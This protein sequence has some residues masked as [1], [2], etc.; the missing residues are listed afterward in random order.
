MDCPATR[1]GGPPAA[2]STY[3]RPPP[4]PRRLHP[5]LETCRRPRQSA[6]GKDG[7]TLTPLRQGR[8]RRPT[9]ELTAVRPDGSIVKTHL[10]APAPPP[11][12]PPHPDH[13]AQSVSPPPAA[14]APTSH[15]PV[16][17]AAHQEPPPVRSTSPRQPPP[18]P[19]PPGAPHTPDNT[20]APS[21]PPDRECGRIGQA[22]RQRFLIGSRDLPISCVFRGASAFLPCT[23]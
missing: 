15:K 17:G 23:H 5:T 9:G 2:A 14:P 3:P 22:R 11:A 1:T 6:R 13:S 12:A 8:N 4:R 20:T 7:R 21:A 18:D 19:S 10:P 16:A